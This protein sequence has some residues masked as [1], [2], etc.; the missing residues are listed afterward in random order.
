MD[1]KAETGARRH[2]ADNG[3]GAMAGT[4]PPFSAELLADLHAGNIPAKVSEQL[5]PAVRRDPA[6]MRY[7]HSLDQVNDR[8]RDL[9][10]DPRILHPMP[11][12]VTERLERMID[13][14]AAAPIAATTAPTATS[15]APRAAATVHPLPRH[16]GPA[17]T[18]P[19]PVRLPPATAPMP[20]LGAAIFD[21]G[22]LD[23][24][25]LEADMPGADGTFAPDSDG[26]FEPEADDTPIRLPERPSRRLRWL[27]AAAAVAAVAAGGVVA[28]DALNSRTVA[29]GGPPAADTQ[30]AADLPPTVVLSAMGNQ[31]FTGPLSAGTNLTACLTAA[32]LNRPI[33]GARNVTY[34]NQQA[35]LVLLPGAKTPQITAVVLGNGCGA[36]NP[37]VLGRADIG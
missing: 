24:R 36:G 16:S 31:S 30:L 25:E 33:L 17:G 1:E 37:Q 26:G 10:R 13:E 18:A 9:G 27:T 8:V 22:R 29:P 14:L 2:P 32:G 12:D 4:M 28:V 11:A 35:V 21:T 34:S 15:T 23:P 7:L 5:W 19:Q 20:A 3:A 6:A